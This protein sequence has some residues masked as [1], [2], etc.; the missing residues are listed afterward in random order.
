MDRTNTLRTNLL[1]I[2]PNLAKCLAAFMLL[3]C[4]SSYTYGVD[5]SSTGSGLWSN[6]ATW[7]P[8]GVPTAA[9]NVT[10]LTGHVIT[11]PSGAAAASVCNNLTIQAS[12]SMQLQTKD[13]TTNGTT[14]LSGII[15]DVNNSGIVT[16][17]GLVTVNS[18]GT[19]NTSII[20][21]STNLIFQ[22]G[23]DCNS[24][25]FTG[26]DATFST[27]SQALSGSQPIEFLGSVII[28]SGVTLTNNNANGFILTGTGATIDGTD[29]TSSLVNEALMIFNNQSLSMTTAGTVDFTSNPNT[30]EYSSDGFNQDVNPWTYYDLIIGANP[31]LDNYNRIAEGDITV[32]NDF[33]LEFG[34]DFFVD[35]FNVTV[36]GNADISGVYSDSDP[37]GTNSFNNLDVSNEAIFSGTTANYGVYT[38][39]GNLTVSNDTVS[40]NHATFSVTGT[41]T[42]QGNAALR[43]G[44]Q[45]GT[46]TFGSVTIDEDGELYVDINNNGTTINIGGALNN[47]GKME[48]Q[49]GTHTFSGNVTNN[50]TGTFNVINNGS[51][52]FGGDFSNDG[53]T[54]I[55]S[56]SYS[57][58][59]GNL[60]GTSAVDFGGGVTINSGA[61]LTNNN[62][63]G[64][65]FST[66]LD[67]ADGTATYINNTTT[68]YSPN[69]RDEP[70]TNGTLDATASGNTF[71]YSRLGIA[72]DVRAGTY[73]NLTFDNGPAD[74]ELA[75]GDVFVTGDLNNVETVTGAFKLFI[76]GSTDQV[77]SG[78]GTVRSLTVNKA[79]GNLSMTND[80]DVSEELIMQ[81]GILNTGTEIVRLG[82]TATITETTSSYVNGLVRSIRAINAGATEDFDGIGLTITADIGT[83]L[84][85]TVVVRQTGTSVLFGGILRAFDIVPS[86]NTGLN[87]SVTFNYTDNELNGLTEANF[88]L[89]E[90]TGGGF[91]SIGGTLDAVGNNIS[92]SGINVFGILTVGDP[93]IFPVEWLDFIAYPERGDIVL[94]WSTA[95]EIN[96]DFFSVERSVDGVIFSSIAKVE[97]AGTTNEIQH[98]KYK[99]NEGLSFNTSTLY[100]RIRQIDL[101]G[102]FD[103]SNVVEV[104]L[105]E[106]P[107]IDIDAYPSPFESE[108]NINVYLPEPSVANVRVLNMNGR[109]LW[110]KQI[111]GV[112]GNNIL[113]YN[114]A[115]LSP[116]IYMIEVTTDFEKDFIRLVKN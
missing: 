39:S 98:Y 1:H 69:T 93:S 54:N 66:R 89:T 23:I 83:A 70:M 19:F 38:V 3:L 110:K 95:Q 114:G 56:G 4:F 77:I 88:Q 113:T 91:T 79:A 36:S 35:E 74:R 34:A 96:N 14:S 107:L 62:S 31:G 61:T 100:Y 18:T 112:N 84:G 51:F 11:M 30:V 67:G 15:N 73:F 12:G 75:D 43:I 42:I 8:A 80:F 60:S 59:T 9:D 116:G 57:F 71:T 65:T 87:A 82:G 101:N 103:Y 22:G 21:S 108:V 81:T 78:G 37:L 105:D 111:T 32:N 94:E 85:N 46:K 72:Q 47:S 104:T 58:A 28:G 10:I 45:S 48:F 92:L 86:T 20:N 2:L 55:N 49:R 17:V 6:P 7:S 99:D 16:F 97:G 41:T 13:H 50:S 5:R 25:N 44:H 63:G 53:S 76:N 106:T 29:G 27:N 24:A 33:T 102:Q 52:S 68:I 26:E 90:D 115:D 40:I 64:I 109:E